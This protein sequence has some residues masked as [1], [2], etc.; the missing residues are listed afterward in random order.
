MTTLPQLRKELSWRTLFVHEAFAALGS[1]PLS[2]LCNVIEKLPERLVWGQCLA[3]N[4]SAAWSSNVDH[5]EPAQPINN[6]DKPLE[7]KYTEPEQNTWRWREMKVGL[8]WRNFFF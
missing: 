1:A 6:T 7:E 8:L 3:L 4:Q 5:A 2:K